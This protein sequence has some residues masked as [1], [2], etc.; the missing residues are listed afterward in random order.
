M[1]NVTD[2]S[3]L[4]PDKLDRNIITAIM[5]NNFFPRHY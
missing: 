2:T 5:Y 3:E 1:S 4:I